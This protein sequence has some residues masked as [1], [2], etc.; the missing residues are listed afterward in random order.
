[1]CSFE[2]RV[3]FVECIELFYITMF[4]YSYCLYV[5]VGESIIGF[6]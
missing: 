6:V 1:M 3:L 5:L 4:V 2:Y